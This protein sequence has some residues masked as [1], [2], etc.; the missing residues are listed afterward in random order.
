MLTPT[1]LLWFLVAFV[2]LLSSARLLG[3]ITRAL[4]QPQ[5]IGELLAGIVL[6]PSL[7]GGVFPGFFHTVFPPS[8]VV[9]LLSQVLSE[10][11]VIFLLFLSGIEVD[12]GLVKS[13]SR[14]AIVIATASVIVPFVIGFILADTLPKALIGTQHSSL[15]F[16]LFVAT[17]LS[18]SA[19]PVIV[20]ILLDMSLLR[21]DVGQLAVAAGVL[22]DMAGWSLLSIVAGIASTKSLQLG[23]FSVSILGTIAFAIFSFTLGFRLIRAFLRWLDDH[24][25]GQGATFTA[26]IVLGLGGA[27]ITQALHMEAFLGAF[28]I[29]IQFARIPRV[30]RD[31]RKNL[32]SMTLS[33]FAP[34]FFAMAGLKVNIIQILTPVLLISTLAVIVV[35]TL[36]KFIGTYIGARLV[37]VSKGM[38]VSLGAGMNA[39]GA[40]E[41]IVATVGL[42][43]KVISSPMYSIIVIMAITTSAMAPVLLRWSLN[44]TPTEP[45]EAARLEEEAFKEKSFIHSLHR[46]LVP[47]WNE[48][49]FAATQVVS[50]LSSTKDLEALVLGIKTGQSILGGEVSQTSAGLE[51]KK[52]Q[53]AWKYREIQ[54]Q[55]QVKVVLAEAAKGYDLMVIEAEVSKKGPHLF[56]GFVDKLIQNAPCNVLVLHMPYIKRDNLKIEKILVPTTG[57][58]ADQK[59][60]E[61][62]LSLAKG[63]NALI[64]TIHIVETF[65]KE[66]PSGG[67]VSSHQKLGRKATDE[68]ARLGRTL[69]A[70]VR[71]QVQLREGKSAGEEIVHQAELKD[72]DLVLMSAERRPSNPDELWVGR[73][74]Y[75]VLRTAK[76]PVGV[77]FGPASSGQGS[78]A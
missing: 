61:L 13:K 49:S 42:Q 46:I 71:S 24:A 53:V 76:C 27:A 59:T 77:L 45:Q 52:D 55:D 72:C 51:N 35:A 58:F 16:K 57:T 17:A 3:Q 7:I 25:S 73:T 48:R 60:A 11:G 63:P 37:K 18:I 74:V 19:I 43:M 12:F 34:V 8:G 2:I 64:D 68:V 6:G 75:R 56:E 38:A 33:V 5:V 1:N 31:I 44:K 30:T 22:N 10:L 15:V 39:R 69:Q 78:N 70:P 21:R 62:G 41:I 4:G 29:G 36:G 28:I 54:T 23:F 14:P 32:E 26:A 40:V 67:S 65:P 66:D 50:H 20:K 47:V 9:S